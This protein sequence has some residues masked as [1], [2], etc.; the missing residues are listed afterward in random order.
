MKNNRN[1]GL[2]A[3]TTAFAFV[4]ALALGMPVG[5][6]ALFGVVAICPLMM[7]FMMRSMH[8]MGGDD[9]HHD[10][11]DGRDPLRKTDDHPAH[12]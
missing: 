9:R 3:I 5:T 7:V 12:R 1:Y 10:T 2:Y 8:G 11:D 4:G 6:L